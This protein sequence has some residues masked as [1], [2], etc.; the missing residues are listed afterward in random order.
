MFLS[1]G[2]EWREEEEDG[3]EDTGELD[4][5]ITVAGLLAL[6][7]HNNPSQTSELS[8][9]ERKGWYL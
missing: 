2:G 1:G 3:W 9:K 5:S 6:H 4:C 7:N 8:V